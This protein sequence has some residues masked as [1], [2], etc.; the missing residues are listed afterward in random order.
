[1]NRI[2][3]TSSLEIIPAIDDLIVNRDNILK[4]LG[5]KFSD[6]DEYLLQLIDHLLAQCK[7]LVQPKA[8]YALFSNPIFH[9]QQ[10]QVQLDAIFFE[11]GK[12]VT[13]FLKKSD[14]I[15]V[16]ACTIGAQVEQLAKQQMND[17]NALEGYI[18]DLIGSELA[19]GVADYLHDHL[20]KEAQIEGKGL[21]NRF[22]PGYCN[23]PVVQQ[24][25]LFLLLGSGVCGITLTP[26]ALM[27][28][29]KSVSGI[30]GRGKGLKRADYKCRLCDDEKCI[31]RHRL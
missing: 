28:P 9:I 11:T 10:R 30:I 20:E 19:E 7:T 5:M 14:A 8:C 4:G 1:M 29:V 26:S 24:H 31:L 22:S 21:T 6:A 23:W 12:V 27:L 13:N 15:I 18:V 17:G 16:F 25:E 2:V 3:S